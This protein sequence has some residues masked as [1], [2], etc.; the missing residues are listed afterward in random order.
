VAQWRI[1]VFPRRGK[2]RQCMDELQRY[3]AGGSAIG[4]GTAGC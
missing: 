4:T 3:E 1:I 2:G